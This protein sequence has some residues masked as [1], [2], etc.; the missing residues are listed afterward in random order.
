MASG[1]GL[2]VDYFKFALELAWNRGLRHT[3]SV[4]AVG[5]A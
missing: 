2:P 1:V 3:W 5:T 4:P